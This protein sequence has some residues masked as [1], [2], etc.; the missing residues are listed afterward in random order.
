MTWWLAPLLFVGTAAAEILGCW[1]V[2]RVLRQ[3]ASAWWLLPAALALA[4]FAWSLTLHPQ[5]AG[6]T[7]AAYGGVYVGTALTWLWLVEG[8]APDRWDLLGAGLIL[9]GSL[10]IVVSHW[11]RG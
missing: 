5:A 3:G 10:C 9:I 8:Q 4:A 1:W 11:P 2:W 7:Y 6:R